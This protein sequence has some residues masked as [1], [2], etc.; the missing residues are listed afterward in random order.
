MLHFLLIDDSFPINTRNTKILQSIAQHYGEQARISVITWDRANDYTEPRAGYYVYQKASAYGQ[1][2]QKLMNLWGYRQFCHERIK[3]LKPDVVIASHWNNLLM[4]PK[5]NREKQMFIYENLDAPTEAYLIR[6]TCTMLEHWQMRRVDLT[7][8]ASRFY[9]ELY[10]PKHRQLVLENK[11]AFPISSVRAYHP[12]SPLKIAFIGLLRYPEILSVLIDSV[13]DDGRFQLFF[14]GDGHA[15]KTLEEYAKGEP[16]VF[17]T[18]RYAYEDVASLYQQTD[19][20]WAAYPNRD[21]NV[22]YAISNKFHESLAFGV[23]T[24]YAEQTRL[25]EF[26]EEQHIGVV[27]DPYSAQSVKTLL[28][29]IATHPKN[30]EEMSENMQVFHQKQSSWAENFKDVTDCIDQFFVGFEQ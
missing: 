19:V 16:N 28:N 5:L 7:I 17:F 27:V 13:R 20:V 15:R 6:K 14:H 22:K 18:G 1:K 12:H 23:P 24:I 8:H 29:H 11:P 4:V 2:F 21:F 9:T 26:V 3:S 10:S 25:G 30:L